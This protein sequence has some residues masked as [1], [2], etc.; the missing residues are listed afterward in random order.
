MKVHAKS[1]VLIAHSAHGPFGIELVLHF[2]RLPLDGDASS[3]IFT[4][5]AERRI[6]GEMRNS[7]HFSHAAAHLAADSLSQQRLRAH[8]SPG[9]R[10]GACRL[11]GFAK[12][13]EI[14]DINR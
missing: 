14:D 1:A 5:T 3:R 13:D 12:S 9:R 4:I 2:N 7:R 8:A 6:N 11:S 10:V